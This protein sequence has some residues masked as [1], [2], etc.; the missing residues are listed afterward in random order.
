MVRIFGWLRV[1]LGT[2]Y[3]GYTTTLATE[4]DHI[5]FGF[6]VEFGPNTS[7]MGLTFYLETKHGYGGFHSLFGPNTSNMGLTF[8]LG[9][10]HARFG[11]HNDDGK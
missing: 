10:K 2:I 11:S 6:H 4:L 5:L 9:T 8:C 3:L 1:P 7:N